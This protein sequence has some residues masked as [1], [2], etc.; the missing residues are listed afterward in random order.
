M[1]PGIIPLLSGGG[2]R[3]NPE[4]ERELQPLIAFASS[5]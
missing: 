3:D 1:M 4:L 2:H 5:A